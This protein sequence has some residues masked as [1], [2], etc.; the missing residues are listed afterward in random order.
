MNTEAIVVM[1]I[2]CV[3]LWGGLIVNVAIAMKN[4]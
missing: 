4:K 2:G 1:A 3:I